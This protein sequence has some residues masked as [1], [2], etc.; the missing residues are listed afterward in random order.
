MALTKKDIHCLNEIF[1]T[2]QELRD[3][4]RDIRDFVRQ[5]N[6]R[7]KTEIIREIVDVVTIVMDRIENHE[8]RLVVL[9]S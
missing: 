4:M 9:E 6:N 2:K 3:E 1:A 5:E 8:A 7:M